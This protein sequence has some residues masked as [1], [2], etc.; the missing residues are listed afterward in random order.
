M[1]QMGILLPLSSLPSRW[2]VGEMGSAAYDWIDILEASGME[3]WQILPL[4]P[5]GYGNSPYQPY[6]SYAG[7]EL[8]ISLE[9]LAEEGLLLKAPDS[10]REDAASID[11]DQTRTW[12]ETHL[13]EAFGN[14]QET[15]EYREFISQPWV[16]EYG[17]FRGLKKKNGGVCWNQWSK[18]ERRWPENRELELD[19]LQEEINYQMFLQF[20]F[21]RQWMKVKAYANE[22]NIKI[23]GDVPFYVGIDSQDVWAGKENFLL[24]VNGQPTFIAG[25]PPDYFS[26]TG[27]RWGNP[28]YDWSY[29]EQHN[30]QFWVERI[31]YSQKLFDFIRIDH[32]RAFDTFWKIPSS[33]PTAVVGE[34]I[35][36]PGYQV[37]DR[38]MEALPGIE[39]IAEDLG[40]LRPEVHTLK[41]HY[42]LKGMKIIQFVLD[43]SGKYARDSDAGKE[44]LIVY[45]G[46]HDNGTTKEW[47][48]GLSKA[49]QR[50]IR[51][52]LKKQGVSSGSPVRGLIQYAIHCGGEMTIIPA[53]DILEMG[54]EARLNTPGTVG[55]PNWE[56][57]LTNLGDFKRVIRTYRRQS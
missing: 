30:F 3:I 35:E 52:W 2:G 31:G 17:V 22:R 7:D 36:A 39:L 11:Y 49:R 6:S 28:I 15:E 43:A 16:Y 18:E 53:F 44:N 4:N 33:C 20:Q 45:T 51:K 27:Q 32:F 25:V 21:Y 46:T 14:F 29:L 13:R 1:K 40:D 37:L 12:K 9:I 54:S 26:E 41:N 24:D 23:M 38:L 10:F 57:K 56:W 8:Y 5:T 34:W 19:S 55:S 48:R 50:K 42:H 47:Y